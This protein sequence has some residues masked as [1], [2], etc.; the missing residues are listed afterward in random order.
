MEIR[1]VTQFCDGCVT[2]QLKLVSNFVLN[3]RNTN[4]HGASARD[5]CYAYAKLYLGPNYNYTGVVEFTSHVRFV[6][7]RVR[8]CNQRVNHSN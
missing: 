5:A 6:V 3:T 7:C 4:T 8:M 1:L 2:F